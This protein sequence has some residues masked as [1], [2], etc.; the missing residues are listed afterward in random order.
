MSPLRCTCQE[1]ESTVQAELSRQ[2]PPPSSKITRKGSLRGRLRS[3]KLTYCQPSSSA[4][5]GMKLCRR[6][7]GKKPEMLMDHSPMVPMVL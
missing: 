3:K 2:M 7:T 5:G 4:S 1:K 6:P